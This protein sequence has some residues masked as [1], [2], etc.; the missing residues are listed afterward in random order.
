MIKLKHV[1][2]LLALMPMIVPVGLYAA[3]HSDTGCKSCHAPHHAEDL[4]G[5]P[6]WNGTET[7]KNFTLYSSNTLQATVGQP[8]GSSKLC[9]GCHDG[10]LQAIAGS[11]MDFGSDLSTSH[12]ISFTYDSALAIADPGLKD[13][14]DPSTLGS[15]IEIDLLDGT[16]KVQCTSCHDVHS[17]GVGTSY[18][19]GYDYFD[20]QG[21]GDLCR[22]CHEK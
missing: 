4:P 21:G 10:S 22:M 13:P 1:I 20:G 16:S 17:S 12:P 15:T 14:G 11:S 3:G 5:V 2:L 19:R 6:L 9:L 18:L 8:D 7:T